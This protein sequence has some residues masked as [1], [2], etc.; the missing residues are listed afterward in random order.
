MMEYFSVSMG[1]FPPSIS[2]EI[3]RCFFSDSQIPRKVGQEIELIGESIIITLREPEPING[4]RD[5]PV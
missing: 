3:I 5:I 2:L 4:Q 1:E